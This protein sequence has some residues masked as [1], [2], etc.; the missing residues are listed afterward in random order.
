MNHLK[1]IMDNNGHFK[2]EKA[3]ACLTKNDNLKLHFLTL[4]Q[5]SLFS[6]KKPET[7]LSFPYHYKPTPFLFFSKN[8]EAPFLFFKTMKPKKKKLKAPPSA[9]SIETKRNKTNIPFVSSALLFPSPV[10]IASLLSTK[11]RG[12]IHRVMHGTVGPLAPLCLS[13]I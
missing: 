5:A 2:G 8:R 1:Q 11:R 6:K 4:C 12:S 10:K 7:V 3:T 9:F 13:E